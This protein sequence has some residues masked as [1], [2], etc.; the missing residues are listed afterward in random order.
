MR[1]GGGASHDGVMAAP[2]GLPRTPPVNFPGGFR[3]PPGP[4]PGIISPGEAL[5][6]AS[7]SPAKQPCAG[8]PRKE[9]GAAKRS[10]RR[11]PSLARNL[12]LG[13][14]CVKDFLNFSL[15][16]VPEGGLA[17]FF[18]YREIALELVR[19]AD[20]SCILMCGAGPGDLGGSR[21]SASAENPRTTGPKISSQTAFRY[22]ARSDK[23]SFA[24]SPGPHRPREGLEVAP[25]RAPLHV[26]PFSARQTNSKAT[27]GFFKR[28]PGSF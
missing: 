13:R 23:L 10:C 7:E 11:P 16:W 15:G 1:G 12:L 24:V 20:F 27:P 26:H 17:G 2:G 9:V 21:G 18:G 3:H 14:F 25:V 4:P 28:T 22:P 8:L 6:L 19:F 5:L